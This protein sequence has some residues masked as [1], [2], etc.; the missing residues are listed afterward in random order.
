MNK[1]VPGLI[2]AGFVSTAS[3][4][5]TNSVTRTNSESSQAPASTN[6]VQQEFEALEAA[7][8]A[9]HEEVDKW[10]RENQEFAAKGAAVPDEQLNRRIRSRLDVVRKGYEDFLRRHPDHAKA[11]LAF[12]S[13][14]GE[15]DDEGEIEH[16]EKAKELDPKDPAVWNNLANY[17]GHSGPIKKAFE[18]YEKAIELNP[19]EPVYY[20]NFGTTVYLFRKDAKE[21][22]KIDEQQVFDKAL[23]LYSNSTRLDAT[24]FLLASDVAQTY[25]GIRPLRTNDA[26]QSW[27]NALSLAPDEMEREGV[28]VHLARIKGSVGRIGEARAHLAAVTNSVYDDLKKRLLRRLDEWEFG[29]NNSPA[30]VNSNAP[31]EIKPTAMPQPLPGPSPN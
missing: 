5:T 19:A 3:A 15:F 30:V 11:H 29:T 13:F 17:Y 27:T 12:A 6:A 10:I 31:P 21:Y 18:Y 8:D 24:N 25:Y 16:L 9:A 1:L 23:N 20:H 7:D 26:L 22:F 14:L 2:L 28:Y 4:A